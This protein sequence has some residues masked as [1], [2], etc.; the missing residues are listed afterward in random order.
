MS[1][2]KGSG[3]RKRLQP[4]VAGLQHFGFSSAKQCPLSTAA[5]EAEF[6]QCPK[7]RS[8]FSVA[9]IISHAESCKAQLVSSQPEGQQHD[10]GTEQSP[11]QAAAEKVSGQAEMTGGVGNAPPLSHAQA[12]AHTYTHAQVH[13]HTHATRDAFAIM[14]SSALRVDTVC[15]ASFALLL[16]E[17]RLLPL[18]SLSAVHVEQRYQ[19]IQAQTQL[20]GGDTGI[21]GAGGFSVWRAEANLRKFRWHF[22]STGPGDCGVQHRDIRLLLSTN[23]RPLVPGEAAAP[24][25]GTGAGH[26]GGTHS[27]PMG[28][29]KSMLQK[30]VRRR[31]V[32]QALR[33]AAAVLE[34]TPSGGGWGGAGGGR[35]AGG[36]G[37]GRGA[38]GLAGAG[39]AGAT[40]ALPGLAE[41]MR[42]LPIICME[43]AAL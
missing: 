34:T 14:R 43:D 17:G 3:K 42:R 15:T 8:L 30:A 16:L 21:G 31:Q 28:L 20:G 22:G 32:L 1:G 18:F 24:L 33:L 29:L 35:A 19:Q 12:H 7:C 10:G 9:A 23:L 4:K 41:L 6:S 5:D 25:A 37:G 26:R 39:E 40:S 36:S 13:A 2:S 11:G 38:A 27:I